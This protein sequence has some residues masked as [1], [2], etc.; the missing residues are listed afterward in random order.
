MTQCNVL[1]SCFPLPMLPSLVC[2]GLL[3]LCLCGFIQNAS[4]SKGMGG[5]S[6]ANDFNLLYFIGLCYFKNLKRR[7]RD[8]KREGKRKK[9]R[10][11]ERRSIL[12]HKYSWE[13]SI[14]MPC[15]G[16]TVYILVSGRWSF[17]A[18]R[19]GIPIRTCL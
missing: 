10:G 12:I 16:I 9:E 2:C 15:G 1:T 18:C 13:Q 6:Y 14:P 7:V 3:Q 4:P 11:K 17:C 8:G 19:Y 5:R